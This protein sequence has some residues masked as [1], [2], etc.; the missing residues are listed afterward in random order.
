[1]VRVPVLISSFI[2]IFKY[3]TYCCFIAQYRASYERPPFTTPG[4]PLT[5]GQT[6]RVAILLLI[7]LA[8]L[9]AIKKSPLNLI[10]RFEIVKFITL[11]SFGL[12]ALRSLGYTDEKILVF[13]IISINNHI[14]NIEYA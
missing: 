9:I 10:Y 2:F 12:W 5:Y 11:P 6:S 3:F 14:P 1:M 13:K 7:H 8:I 4:G